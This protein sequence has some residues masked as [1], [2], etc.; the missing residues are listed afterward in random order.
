[1]RAVARGTRNWLRECQHQFKNH[2]WNCSTSTRDQR[3]FGKAIL[4]SSRE[5][6]FVYAISSAGVVHAVARACGR[7][8][9]RACACGAPGHASGDFAWAGCRDH[10]RYATRFARAFVDAKERA[11]KDARA[12]INLHNNRSGR[13]AVKRFVSR[14][15]KCHGVSGSCS[16]RTCWYALAELRRSGDFLRRRYDGA[17]RVALNQDGSGFIVADRHFKQPSKSDLVYSEPSPDYCVQDQDVGSLGTDGR[18]CNKSSRGTDSCEVMCCGRGYDTRR[19]TRTKQCECKF[20]W[21]CA[22]RCR[23]CRDTVDVHTCKAAGR[24]V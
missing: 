7:G 11:E 13:K 19:V 18:V 24:D 1:M 15:C 3:L 22:V 23:E 20:R 12:L 10:V 8:E 17:V 2:R 21:C 4:R 14:E 16:L 9:L 5:S 6:A